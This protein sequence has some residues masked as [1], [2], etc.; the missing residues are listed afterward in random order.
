M[1]A[2]SLIM[3]E[4]EKFHHHANHAG[5]M[6]CNYLC[7]LLQLGPVAS[8]VLQPQ[9]RLPLALLLLSL[10]LLDLVAQL[11]RRPD[12]GL[13]QLYEATSL[14]AAEVALARILCP[15]DVVASAVA[16]E[17]VEVVGLGAEDQMRVSDV[18]EEIQALVEAA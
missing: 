18:G 10:L 13:H 9:W 16:F 15:G 12:L 11:H 14:L 17:E 4:S 5:T 7:E 8:V 1:R 2:T 3:G 6:I